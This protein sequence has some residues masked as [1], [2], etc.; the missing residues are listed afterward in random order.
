M[1]VYILYNKK[2]Y[3]VF[4]RVWLRFFL[5]NKRDFGLIL[6]FESEGVLILKCERENNNKYK[7]SPR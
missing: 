2:G 7:K 6:V 4:K 5:I 1:V 3:R